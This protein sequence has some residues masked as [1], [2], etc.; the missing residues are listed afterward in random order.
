M[1]YTFYHIRQCFTAMD[2]NIDNEEERKVAG[3]FTTEICEH[4]S[5]HSFMT[6]IILV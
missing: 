6:L 3:A 4:I 2:E 5:E 1:L